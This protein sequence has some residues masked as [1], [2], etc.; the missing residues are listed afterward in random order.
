MIEEEAIKERVLWILSG[1]DLNR[2]NDWEKEFVESIEERI[3]EGLSLTEK[4]QNVLE[5]IYRSNNW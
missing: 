1:L 5:D 4:Q 2:L 3:D